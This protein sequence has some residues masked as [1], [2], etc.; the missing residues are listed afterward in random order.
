MI[1]RRGG[2]YN[3]NRTFDTIAPYYIAQHHDYIPLLEGFQTHGQMHKIFL[4]R[5]TEE[6]N[7]DPFLKFGQDKLFAIP[8]LFILPGEVTCY[9]G[10]DE[11][12][13]DQGRTEFADL[14]EVDTD[15]AGDI[16]QV[17]SQMQTSLDFGQRTSNVMSITLDDSV[18]GQS[19]LKRKK[20]GGSMVTQSSKQITSINTEWMTIM[21]GKKKLKGRKATARDPFEQS[22]YSVRSKI[23]FFLFF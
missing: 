17:T 15:D 4:A 7:D 13:D 16:N 18:N 6:L 1:S 21:D 12:D 20:R 2:L 22:D 14:E 19:I 23:F 11:F 9:S 5:S 3:C 8:G 10:G